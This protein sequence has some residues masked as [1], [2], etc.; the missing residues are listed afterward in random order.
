MGKK[1]KI[2]SGMIISLLMLVLASCSP[3]G[4]KLVDTLH[5]FTSVDTA[6]ATL[7][8]SGLDFQKD[9]GMRDEKGELDSL[10]ELMI[11]KEFFNAYIE[12]YGLY[13]LLKHYNAYL[14]C[15]M[16]RSDDGTFDDG[17]LYID[18]IND[19]DSQIRETLTSLPEYQE[20]ENVVINAKELEKLHGSE[21]YYSGKKD[22]I[23]EQDTVKGEF[24]DSKNDNAV[25]ESSR[26]NRTEKKYY[27]DWEVE[28]SVKYTYNPGKYGW[29]NG[30]FEDEKPSWEEKS[31]T[32]VYYKGELFGSFENTAPEFLDIDCR[33]VDGNAFIWNDNVNKPGKWIK[34]VGSIDIEQNGNTQDNVKENSNDKTS[35]NVTNAPVVINDGK[36]VITMGELEEELLN[37]FQKVNSSIKDITNFDDDVWLQYQASSD[38]VVLVKT[39][40]STD[41][42]DP[43]NV[44]KCFVIYADTDRDYSSYFA[45]AINLADPS[46]EVSDA[47]KTL[48]DAYGSAKSSNNVNEDGSTNFTPY[49]LGDLLVAYGMSTVQ[50][51]VIADP[52]MDVN[53]LF[54]EYANK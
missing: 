37:R 39:Q 6:E 14:S 27:G 49:Y 23:N 4:D 8:K 46:V 31:N 24:N 45:Q 30:V 16:V 40:A 18:E 53:Q 19:R 50:M 52:S 34:W 9:A 35:A 47:S 2:I 51:C 7:D 11:N 13:D 3:S 44:I 41:K 38:E 33:I 1:N 20:L 36:Y 43:K 10:K 25:Y 17:Y 54:T 29:N 15:A 12:K 22:E 26:T 32:K 28:Y 48:F 21:G 5:S 42:R